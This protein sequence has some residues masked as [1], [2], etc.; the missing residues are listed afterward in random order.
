MRGQSGNSKDGLNL[1]R[2]DV[3]AGIYTS[4][5][6]FSSFQYGNNV[7]WGSRNNPSFFASFNFFK[8]KKIELGVGFG[9]QQAYLEDDNFPVSPWPIDNQQPTI[10]QTVNY[11]T[12]LPQI[13]LNWFQSYDRFFELYSGLGLAI[14]LVAE[15]Y[16]NNEGNTY[17]PI[18]GVHITGMGVRYGKKL[19]GFIEIGAGSKGFMSAGISYR[20]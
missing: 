19:G 6:I 18:P 3:S 4:K 14:T 13:R 10:F 20:L 16:S 11:Y 1:H 12:L 2:V 17:Y 9:Y 5:D 15:E 7:V 8:Q